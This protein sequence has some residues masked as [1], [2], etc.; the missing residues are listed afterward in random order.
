[1]PTAEFWDV[2]ALTVPQLS[3]L[4]GFIMN[5]FVFACFELEAR[6]SSPSARVHTTGEDETEQLVDGKCDAKAES[7]SGQEPPGSKK[8]AAAAA[9]AQQNTTDFAL[10][11]GQAR[12]SS[13]KVQPLDW[14]FAQ[15]RL[16]VRKLALLGSILLY[17]YMC[18]R[19]PPNPHGKRLIGQWDLFWFIAGGFILAGLLTWKRNPGK[20]APSDALLGRDQTEE[21]KGWMQFLFIEY[22]YFHAVQVY[23]PIRV[24]VSSYVWMTGFGNFSFFYIKRDFS[25]VRLAQ[26]LWRLNFLVLLLVAVMD[27]QYILYYIVPLHTFYTFVVYATMRF[28]HSRNHSDSSFLRWKLLAVFVIILIIW[29]VPGVFNFF[30]AWWLSAE[31][32]PLGGPLHEWHFRSYLD[33]FS[34]AIGMLFALNFPVAEKWL[35]KVEALPPSRQ[36]RAKAPVAAVLIAGTAMWMHFVGVK[37]KYTF[38]ARSPYSFFVPMLCYIFLRNSTKWLRQGHLALFAWAGK[39][40]LET[41]LMQHHCLL[42]SN[43][44]TLLVLVPGYE[45]CNLLL[46]VVIYVW[47]ALRLYRL[48]LHLRAMFIPDTNNGRDAAKYLC[49][50]GIALGL[51]FTVGATLKHV[52]QVRSVP[53]LVFIGCCLALSLLL[54]MRS[55]I[56]GRQLRNT[57]VAVVVGI[58][59]VMLMAASPYVHEGEFLPI[60]PPKMKPPPHKRLFVGCSMT[61]GAFTLFFAALMI[62]L[63]DPFFGT[64]WIGTACAGS[65]AQ[66]SISKAYDDLHEKIG[67]S[68]SSGSDGIE[69]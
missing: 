40:T 53:A 66:F 67:I 56:R 34:T 47:C 44:K 20:L 55:R 60:V 28:R 4:L 21:W 46:V 18:E 1:M 45:K 12:G 15:L 57:T 37:D 52:M 22:H 10:A 23:N 64:V 58:G 13:E 63:K 5:M 25:M 35:N 31:Y 50:L 62:F 32:P 7:D 3:L 54:L 33:H 68:K 29:D 65:Q 8:M 30:H 51:L 19:H 26:L 43:A 11:K 39:I 17:A 14:S 42:T 6:T 27:N 61:K 36:F 2:G 16:L 38:N 69:P 41:Y 48:T 59:F 24:F 9:P 49:N